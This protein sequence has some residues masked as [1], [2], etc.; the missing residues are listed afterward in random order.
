M[1][2]QTLRCL[3]GLQSYRTKG[4]VRCCSWRYYGFVDSHRCCD[5]R[6]LNICFGIFRSRITNTPRTREH[7]QMGLSIINLWP[8]R[9]LSKHVF[10]NKEDV[11]CIDKNIFHLIIISSSKEKPR[12]FIVVFQ[13]LDKISL[14]TGTQLHRFA[15]YSRFFNS[16][17][18]PFRKIALKKEDVPAR[19]EDTDPACILDEWSTKT[20]RHCR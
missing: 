12:L 14:L 17:V 1:L 6:K 8:L 5:L 7:I 10:S 19:Q 11:H 20:C 9:L 13:S 16:S 15:A 3:P 2:N 18:L 4:I